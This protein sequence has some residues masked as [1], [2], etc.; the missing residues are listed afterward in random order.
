[1]LLAACW[2][3]VCVSLMPRMVFRPLAPSVQIKIN[4]IWDAWLA[5]L[6]LIK[7]WSWDSIRFN[8]MHKCRKR[9]PSSWSDIKKW[10]N[11]CSIVIGIYW[12]FQRLLVEALEEV[13]H[14]D[15][16]HLRLKAPFL[17]GKQVVHHLYWPQHPVL[18]LISEFMTWALHFTGAFSPIFWSYITAKWLK[19]HRQWHSPK[20]K[21]ENFRVAKCKH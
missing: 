5:Q 6:A 16:V 18:I 4:L 15:L 12:L 20:M 8:C 10:F 21:M 3:K 2:S 7:Q 19:T 14:L 9:S 17:T 11:L 13:V 1:M